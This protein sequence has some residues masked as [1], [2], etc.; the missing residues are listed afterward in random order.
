MLLGSLGAVISILIIEISVTVIQVMI[1][2]NKIRLS[3]SL[4]RMWRV[5]LAG[6]VMF[7]ISF[8]LTINFNEKLVY[9][10]E[11]LT[12]VHRLLPYVLTTIILGAISGVIYL[13]TLFVLREP[14]LKEIYHKFINIFKKTN[15]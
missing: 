6:I 11:A 14:F 4:L 8:I 1:V 10:F 7:I 13:I 5:Y 15:I 2:K 12:S 9:I 3:T